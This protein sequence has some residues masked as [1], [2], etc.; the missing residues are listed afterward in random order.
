MKYTN[1]TA[2][3]GLTFLVLAS[4]Y[5]NTQ[6]NDAT[7]F[8]MKIMDAFAVTDRGTIVTGRVEAGSLVAG[9]TVCVPLASGETAARKVEAIELFN[10]V[11]ARAEAGKMAGIL[12]QNV[13][14]KAVNRQGVLRTNCALDTSEGQGE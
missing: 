6:D 13:D 12:V 2:L 10:K 1:F 4:P 5:A 11:L 9:A 3:I 7:A 14:A 8:S